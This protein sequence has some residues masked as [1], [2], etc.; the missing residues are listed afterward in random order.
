MR[1][2]LIDIDNREVIECEGKVRKGKCNR[3]GQ[4]CMKIDCKMLSIDSYRDDAHTRPIYNCLWQFNKP[5]FCVIGPL[6]GDI[7]P[8]GCGFYWE[9]K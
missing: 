5:L 9:D 3:C 4:C 2:V 6:P 7:M 8:E 1:L